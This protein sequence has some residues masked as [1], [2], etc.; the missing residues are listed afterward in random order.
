MVAFG[1]RGARH[2]PDA[3]HGRA[4]ARTDRFGWRARGVGCLRAQSRVEQ[5][6]QPLQSGLAARMEEAPVAHAVEAR[7]QGVLEEAAH[8]LHPVDQPGLV[9]AGIPVLDTDANLAAFDG[10]DASVGDDA[11]A[12]VLAEVF[13]R[14]RSA[15]RAVNRCVPVHFD[16]LPEERLVD[17]SG[18]EELVTQQGAQPQSQGLGMEEELRVLRALELPLGVESGSGHD[19]VHMRVE[20]HVLPPALVNAEEAAAGKAAAPGVGQQ[21]AERLGAA[22]HEP[23]HRSAAAT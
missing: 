23:L 16:Q 15:A 4:A 19:V 8:K 2:A 5:Q 1:W 14:V 3:V 17:Q 10:E 21:L 7:W 6:L 12:N 22:A 20:V 9:V 13:D 18:I 11:A